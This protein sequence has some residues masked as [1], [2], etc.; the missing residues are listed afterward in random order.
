MKLDRSF[1]RVAGVAV[2]AF[3]GSLSDNVLADSAWV[4]NLGFSGGIVV[5]VDFANGTEVADLAAANGH[6][7]YHGLFT[8]EDAVD[9]AKQEM[10]AAGLHGQVSCE[11]YNGQDLPYVDGLINLVLCSASCAVPTNELMRVLAPEGMLMVEDSD[12]EWQTTIKPIPSGMDEW[13]Q[14]LHGADNNGVSL[15]D[16][17]PP[18]RIRWHAGPEH[19]RHK[20]NS[21]SFSNMVTADG[22]IF[23]IEDTA[24]TEDVSSPT[25]N[26]L[27][28]RDA[29]NGVELWTMPM[30]DEWRSWENTSIKTIPTQQQR[31]LAAIDK[32]VYF[33]AGFGS[34]V[35]ALDT[36]TGATNQVYDLTDSTAEFLI[37]S[38]TLYGIEGLP[39]DLGDWTTDSA[40]KVFAYDLS[41]GT[42]LWSKEISNEYIG[43]TLAVKGE[44]LVY[45][46]RNGLTCLKS[47]TGTEVWTTVVDLPDPDVERGPTYYD[48]FDNNLQSTL[49]LTDDMVYYVVDDNLAVSK[50]DR[51]SSTAAITAKSLVDGSTVWTA[52]DQDNYMKSPD[53]FVADGLVWG[54]DLKG[55]D[56]LTGEIVRTLTQQVDGPMSHLRC[57]R[58]RITHRF[59]INSASGGTDLVAL[60]PDENPI[61]ESPNPWLR[62]TCGL[63]MMPANGMIYSSPYVCQC[64]M[65]AMIT[66]VNAIYNG[67]GNT[68][69]VFTVELES[70]WVQG[71]A[72]GTVTNGVDATLYDW[73]TYRYSSVRSAVS[74]APAAASV[75]TKWDVDIGSNPTA[76]VIANDTVYVADRDT[77]ILYALNR[78]DGTTRWTYTADGCIDSPP[79]Y[80]KGMLLFGTRTGWVYCLNASDGELVWKFTG[81]PNQ[82]LMCSK[83]RLESAWP[84]SGSVMVFE[85]T[86]YFS[87]GRSSF[88]DGGIGVFALDPTTGAVKHAKMV[89]GPYQ[90][91]NPTFPVYNL[92]D[93][94]GA[95]YMEGFKADIFS[96]NGSEIFVRNQPFSKAL[97]LIAPTNCVEPHIMASTGMLNDSPTHRTYW[98]VDQDLRYPGAGSIFGS[99]PEGDIT[100]YD[101]EDFYEVRSYSNGRNLQIDDSVSPTYYEKNTAAWE[102]HTIYSGSLTDLAGAGNDGDGS[103]V[104]GIGTWSENWQRDVQMSGAAIAASRNTVLVAGV[105]LLQAYTQDQTDA[106]YAGEMGGVAQLLSES[107]GTLLKE[108]TFD[109]A[110]VW[111]GIAIA[112]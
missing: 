9:A 69:D 83:D 51:N 21:P 109:A 8:T 95:F 85:D 105:P 61:W 7:I 41:T 27:V 19:G 50:G 84:V 111:D 24:T 99:G 1:I 59:Y 48:L 98:T 104:P 37:E 82:R 72:F 62:S 58:N 60:N 52:T 79:S 11:R 12:G 57:Y 77:Y 97:D 13:G 103:G 56:P 26:Y 53:L 94:D 10:V 71:P 34:N 5:A 16:V 96:N 47:A 70:Q 44:N 65:G 28:A 106:S 33:C 49:V 108:F 74:A 87:A 101:G 78:E 100:A 42:T 39:Y 25:K 67:C 43:G 40:V 6:F 20:R 63:S 88:L 17:G 110:P 2:A 91:N 81:L 86:V 3:I 73:P 68:G 18:Q 38:N 102:L 112:Y 75:V 54:M 46:C 92:D 15:D 66:G 64:S 45:N 30:P 89:R 80:Y 55:R 22:V 14:F 4:E 23:T 36:R 107:D 93:V 29:H 90:E 32:T 76:P 35:M 31:C